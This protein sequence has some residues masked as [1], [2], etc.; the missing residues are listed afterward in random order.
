M[1]KI[2]CLH[3]LSKIYVQKHKF[4]TE[5]CVMYGSFIKRMWVLENY[6]MMTARKGRF[7]EFVEVI[8]LAAGEDK[9]VVSIRIPP[10]KD[11]E[12][13]ATFSRS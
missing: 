4:P 12:G 6:M 11:G 3:R 9:D 1:P 5:I 7:G 8:L 13:L 10:N 2:L